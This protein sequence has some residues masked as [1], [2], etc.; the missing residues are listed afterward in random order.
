MTAARVLLIEDEPGLAL[1]LGDRLRDAGYDL[2]LAADGELGL[3]RAAT[4]PG[5]DLVLLDVMLPGIDGF[6]VCRGLRK[7]GLRTPVLMLTARGQVEDRVHGLRLG[8]DD[9]LTKPFDPAELLARMEALLRRVPP[10][11]E[12]AEPVRFGDVEVDL[13]GMEVRRGGERVE[14]AQ[15]EFR[16]LAYLIQ[17]EGSVVTREELLR[18]VWGFHHP[19][20]TRTVDV[21]VTWLRSKLEPDR[22]RPVFLYL[23]F[24]ILAYGLYY[25]TRLASS[26]R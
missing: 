18:G 12:G 5:F 3:A 10:S 21:H 20:R 1:T 7:R 22:S 4:P 14:L 19:P 15:L 8:A 16:L 11:A 17:R 13:A 2:E 23:A 26:I 25:G 24:S 9:Y 6:E